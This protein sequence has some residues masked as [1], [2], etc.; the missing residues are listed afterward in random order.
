MRARSWLLLVFALL[1]TSE[2]GAAVA[3]T[4][5]LANR[6]LSYGFDAKTGALLDMQ[7]LATGHRF[8][9]G[10]AGDMWRLELF[11]GGR[12]ITP[13]DARS[14]KATSFSGRRGVQLAWSDFGLAE[15]PSMR[16]VVVVS[17]S[18]EGQPMSDWTIAL[19]STG[20]LKVEQVRFP[21][22][23]GIVRQQ[24]EELIVPRWMGTLARDPQVVLSDTAGKPRRLQYD[25]PG[26]LSLQLVAL[27]ARGGAGFY[28]A[29]DDTLAYRKSFALW[30]AEDDSRGYEQL[31]PLENPQLAHGSWSLQYAAVLGTFHGDWYDAAERY[32]AWGTQQR[33]ARDSRLQRGLVPQWLL[34]T[35]MWVWNRGASPKVLPPARAL[36]DALGLPVSVFWHWWHHGP[37]DTSF[38]DYLPPREG[39]DAFMKA[40]ADA[41]A[42]GLHA[43]VYMNQRLWCTHMPSWGPRAAAAAVKERNGKIREEVYNIFDPKPCATM[44]VT[45]Q[46]WRDTYAG[47][48]DTVL[49]TYRIHGIYMDQAVLSLVCW[50]PTHGHPLGGGNY[51]IHGFNA[52]AAQIRANAQPGRPILLA[53]EGAG[54]PWLPELDLMLTL[55]VSQ[56][57]Y[58]APN[59]GWEPIPLFQSVYHA[60]GITYGSYSSLVLPPYD[61]LWPQATTP[62]DTLALFDLRFRR[63]FY[64][65]Q[66]RSFVWGLQPTIANFRVSQ[67]T[68]R[69]T[70][71]DY[72]MKLAKLRARVP[73]YLLRGTFMRP[74]ALRVPN[75]VLDLSRVSIYAARAGGPTV[76]QSE[77][78]GAI[79]GAWRAA[80]GDIAIAVVSILDE[81]V[82]VSFDV[83][84]AAY[85]L[86]GTGTIQRLEGAET[87]PFGRWT[88]PLPVSLQLPAGGATI[89][90]FRRDQNRP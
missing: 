1:V 20:T 28:A 37:Y 83:D 54:E 9:R 63:Q 62:A 45:Q 12:V 65:E 88:G 43:M 82:T 50:D 19:D 75:A 80:N 13:S 32:R 21:R 86:S 77:Y 5:R 4:V 34:E 38:P 18:D 72:M 60:Y 89:L 24:N 25:Y 8:V 56:E 42:A 87:I 79:A 39:T 66:A 78:P 68:D 41:D 2:A 46:Y 23:E 47:I 81:P 30:R 61:E 49:D 22:I 7:D 73:D 6:A 90:E 71:T 27:Y 74:P 26:A 59:S 3:D 15:A 70:E 48:A 67:L 36:Q 10:T 84:P 17:M 40:V 31:H 76:S 29:T 64:L 11:E 44:D 14:F 55:Q 69:R 58:S 35:G 85:G 33:W 53:G 51:W 52:L 57:R 16:V